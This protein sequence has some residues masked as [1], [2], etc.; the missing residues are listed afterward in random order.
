MSLVHA[1]GFSPKVFAESSW[2]RWLEPALSE[3]CG[4]E[5]CQNGA[6]PGPEVWSA[7][8]AAV[9]QACAVPAL[10]FVPSPAKKPRR[11]RR[12]EPIKLVDLYE[13]KIVERHE[14]PTRLDDW[15]D[16][17]NALAFITFPE[18]KWELHRRQYLRMKER[19]SPAARTLPGARTREQDA[20]SLFDEG[21]LV[22]VVPPARIAEQPADP[23]AFEDFILGLHR[24]GETQ[25][26]P[27]GHALFEHLV[28]GRSDMA[29][30]VVVVPHAPSMPTGRAE[31]CRALDRVLAVRLRDPGEF[32]EPSR[33]RGLTLHK[34]TA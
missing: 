16:L 2:Y 5:T 34:L 4:L 19:L 25:A 15:H 13:G 6:F 21:G 22:V 33:A 14:V 31:L 12:R 10:T 18:S 29:G 3:I 11:K 9:A 17:F 20:L 1:R 30:T 7:L 23:D 32:T 24:A 26:I 8:H 27:F 28:L